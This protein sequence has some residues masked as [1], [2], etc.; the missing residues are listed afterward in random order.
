MPLFKNEHQAYIRRIRV[1]VDSDQRLEG[2]KS[3]FDFVFPLTN[4]IE[5]VVGV[6]MVGYNIKT[7]LQQTFI[8]QTSDQNGNNILDVSVN[9]ILTLSHPLTYAVTIP[10]RNYTTV[11]DL[12]S[13]LQTILRD[14]VTALGDP[15]WSLNLTSRKWV[16]LPTNQTGNITA[17]Y[18]VMGFGIHEIMNNAVF[19]YGTGENRLNS[20]GAQLGFFADEDTTVTVI[21]Y[22]R[23]LIRPIPVQVPQL[24]PFRFLDVSIADAPELETVGRIMLVDDPIFDSKTR[25]I[26]SRPRI[27]TQ[28][29][30][31]METIHVVC[32]MGPTFHEN[33]AE[34]RPPLSRSRGGIDLIFD[35]LVVAQEQDIPSWV[36]QEWTY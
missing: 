20:G 1:Y 25:D 10:P 36:R 12:A 8:A 18:F 15:Y 4:L 27:L 30:K 5:N 29:I 26:D 33:Q 17:L 21:Q 22:G 31:R 23:T 24:K 32:T 9:D 35:I 11:S 3:E 14:A 7:D 16:V 13:N 34:T 2:S 19:E 6:E 28:P